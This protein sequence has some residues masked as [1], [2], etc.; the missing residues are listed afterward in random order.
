MSDGSLVL[1]AA[2][3]AAHQHRNQRRQPG[4]VPYINHPIGV[5]RL[6]EDVG[7]VH[8]PLILAGAL[9][10]DTVEDTQATPEDLISRFGT[11]VAS[12]VA[13]VTDDKGL[14][15]VARKKH[16][17][18]HAATLSDPARVIKLADKLYNLRSTTV[19]PIPTWDLMRIRG[20]LNWGYHVVEQVGPANSPLWNE[21]QA[22]FGST[23]ER[24]GDRHPVVPTTPALRKELLE[25]YYRALS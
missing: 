21:L 5:A 7:G 17:I 19:N 1:R 8:D 10:H 6:I 2:E 25:E 4:D 3:Y 11:E 23:F 9:L 24:D 12:V 15:K 13:E 20:Y 22:L 18:V 16:Q 14:S